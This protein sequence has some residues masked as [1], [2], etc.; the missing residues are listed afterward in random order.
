MIKKID[1][2]KGI[3]ARKTR[4]V[5]RNITFM[6]SKPTYYRYASQKIIC[7]CPGCGCPYRKVKDYSFVYVH[8]VK[9]FIYFDVPKC[10]SSTIRH[11]IFS[12]DNSYSLKDPKREISEYLKFTFVRNPWDRMVSNWKMFTTKRIKQLRSM[13]DLDLSKFEDFADF[14]ISHYNHHWLPQSLYLP[15]KLDFIGRL[16]T[17]DEDFKQLLKLIS[18]DFKEENIKR[19][20]KRGSTKHLPYWEYYSPKLVEKIGEYYKADIEKFNYEFRN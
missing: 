7:H 12:G 1:F 3:I 19:I 9:S 18:W 5:K 10:A 4:R 13:T 2:D 6:I 16:E 8:E 11:F 14:A 15:E 17:F 20:K